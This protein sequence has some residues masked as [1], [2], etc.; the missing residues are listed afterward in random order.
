MS[1]PQELVE[2]QKAIQLLG[3]ELAR[4]EAVQVPLLNEQRYILL[5]KKQQHTPDRYPRSQ[6]LPRQKP[7]L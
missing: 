2:A 1:A 6:G 4:I 7:L 5:I 3:G